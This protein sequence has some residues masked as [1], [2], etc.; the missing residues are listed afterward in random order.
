[1]D[2]PPPLLMHSPSITLEATPPHPS[3][4]ILASGNLKETQNSNRTEGENQIQRF[5]WAELNIHSTFPAQGVP[6]CRFGRG[7]FS[8]FSGALCAPFPRRF[9]QCSKNSEDTFRLRCSRSS[10]LLLLAPPPPRSSSSSL[11]LLILAPP[12][13]RSSASSLLLAPPPPRSS[14]SSSLCLLLAPPP[15]RS[16]SS[17]LLLLAPPP[18][19]SSSLLLLILALPPPSSSLCPISALEKTSVLYR[20]N[21]KCFLL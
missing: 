9:C 4:S 12:P 10:S 7:C 2:T 19:S 3:R 5:V 14:S 20:K 8:A 6:V 13:P 11:L 21:K 1:M 18:R 17:L 15:P 16:S